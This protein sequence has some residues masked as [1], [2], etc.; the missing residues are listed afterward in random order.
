[1]RRVDIFIGQDVRISGGDMAK[2]Q[3]FKVREDL[4]EL[5]SK[6]KMAGNRLPSEAQLARELAVSRGTVREVLQT[7]DKQGIISKKHGQGNFIHLSALD[8]KM[9]IDIIQDF[10][11]LIASSGRKARMETLADSGE[12]PI[13]DAF[14]KRMQEMME[15]ESRQDLLLLQSLYY[16]DD[17][18]A[19]YSQVY[20]PRSIILED[21]R[22]EKDHDFFHFLEE[23]CEESVDQTI[24]KFFPKAS[25]P[26]ISSV[27]DME[28]GTP[29]IEWEEYY[30][31]VYDEVI[32]AASTY[33]N[34][35]VMEF[36]MLRKADDVQLR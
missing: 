12:T 8:T 4:I 21:P 19:I 9:R 24:I 13:D 23:Y 6:E 11:D 33:F 29:Y 3:Y 31:N 2:K 7:L 28:E 36:T 17:L 10:N 14:F 35:Q 22:E 32:S 5:I 25:S 30:Y 18:P 34:P 15:I 16:A 26:F 1:M 20:L 27:L